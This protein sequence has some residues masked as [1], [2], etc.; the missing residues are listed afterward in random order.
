MR[1][2]DF[3]QSNASPGGGPTE[4]YGV[5]NDV[6]DLP[7]AL[8]GI[9]KKLGVSADEVVKI[10]R[11]LARAFFIAARR[12]ARSEALILATSA[13][14]ALGLECRKLAE[15]VEEFGVAIFVVQERIRVEDR[16]R[17]RWTKI[18][19]PSAALPLVRKIIG[20]PLSPRRDRA[21]SSPG[22]KWAAMV[23]R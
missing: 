6:P 9:S 19:M 5:D 11:R 15:A 20:R 10:H 13:V 1:P 8:V 12:L 16:C 3:D 17:A 2:T 21:R 7:E 14:V 22:G 4:G 23:A 18:V